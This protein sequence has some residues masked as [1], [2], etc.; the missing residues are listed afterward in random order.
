MNYVIASNCNWH[1]ELLQNVIDRIK[2]EVIFISDKR[3]LIV[4]NLE[5]IGAKTIF[6]PHWSYIIPAEIYENYECIIFH[7]TDLPF[8]RGGSPLQNLIVR[9]IYETQISGLRCVKELDA[10]HIYMKRP[11]SLYGTAQEMFMRVNQIIEDMIVSIILEQPQPQPQQGE[12]S[13]FKRRKESESNI[14]SLKN[15]EQVHDYIRMLDAEGYPKA[16]LE[17][18]HLKFEFSRVSRKLDHLLADVVIK[19]KTNE[20]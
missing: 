7:M 9:G 18:E 13:I 11:L 2:D 17:T 6:F 10:G 19:L 1:P 14:K 4:E 5:S 12:V 8:G 20:K 15:L 3:E 16:F